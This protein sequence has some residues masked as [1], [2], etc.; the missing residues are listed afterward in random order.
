MDTPMEL[1][2]LE[3]GEGNEKEPVFP[4]LGLRKW[5]WVF[6]AYAWSWKRGG[7]VSIGFDQELFYEKSESQ[8]WI[9]EGRYYHIVLNTMFQIGSSHDYYDGPHCCFSLGFLH[10]SW[11][12]DWCEKCMPP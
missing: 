4:D 1:R 10:F 7:S 9:S 12:P 8:K 6:G 11:A 2:L 5:R 3:F